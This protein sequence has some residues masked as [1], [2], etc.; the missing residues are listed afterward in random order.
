[1]AGSAYQSDYR[2]IPVEFARQLESELQEAQKEKLEGYRAMG[3]QIADALDER[4]QLRQQISELETRHAA[5]MLHTQS[6][7]DENT[8]S[9]RRLW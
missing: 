6:V 4:D 5:T 3:K 7:V 1:M 8:K 2:Y 9:G